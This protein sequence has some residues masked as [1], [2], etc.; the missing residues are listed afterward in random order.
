MSIQ[1][2]IEWI[3]DQ[4]TCFLIGAGCGLCAGK[5][6]IDRLTEEVSKAL[7]QP[8]QSLLADLKGN[9]GRPAN[10]EDL[11]NY[12]LRKR[13]LTDSR[14]TPPGKEDWSIETIDAELLRIQ[15]AIV[16]AIGVDWKPSV[17]H[18]RFMARLASTLS[19][20][21]IDIFS[22]NYDTVLEASLEAIKL[23]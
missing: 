6:N 11:I 3:T 18:Q 14:K 22:L 23:R 1:S 9:G 16:H 2:I 8:V 20:K 21:P 19:R 10:V 13:Q 17:Y 12:L 5:P 15:K 7:S 4:N